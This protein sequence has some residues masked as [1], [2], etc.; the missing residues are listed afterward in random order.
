MVF[1]SSA[2]SCLSWSLRSALRAACWAARRRVRFDILVFLCSGDQVLPAG[3]RVRLIW[4]FDSRYWAGLQSGILD[5]TGRG[6]RGFDLLRLGGR[7]VFSRDVNAGLPNRQWLKA[8]RVVVDLHET[9]SRQG[10]C[11]QVTRSG[12]NRK[13]EEKRRTYA[14]LTFGPHSPTIA[15]NDALAYRQP[16]ARALYFGG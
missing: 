8:E 5:M 6:W 7:E 16:Q 13:R 1:G 4:I 3:R 9:H 12:H 14:W 11:R 15:L 10:Y 2:V